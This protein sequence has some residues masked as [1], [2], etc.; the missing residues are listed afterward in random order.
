M[1]LKI[2]VFAE[3]ISGAPAPPSLELLSKARSMGGEVAA[4]YAGAGSDEAFA[5]LGAHGAARVFHIETGDALPTGGLAAA[6]AGLAEEHAPDLI[7]FG[8][9]FNDRDVA[10]R[11]SARLDRPVL[12]NAVDLTADGGT[13]TVTSE[14]LGG[15]SIVEAAFTGPAPWLAIARPKAFPAEPAGAAAPEVVA[16]PIGETG[17]ARILEH[18]EETAEGPQLED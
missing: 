17:P 14:I 18:H 13:V 9:G 3:E 5:A 1:A 6:I 8:M 7:L 11:L 2:W 16:V 4:V 10:G 12:A 15:T